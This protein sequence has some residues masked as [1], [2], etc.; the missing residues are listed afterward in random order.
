MCLHQEQKGSVI[1]TITTC[2]YTIT[3]VDTIMLLAQDAIEELMFASFQRLETTHMT[4][5]QN[6][7]DMCARKMDVLQS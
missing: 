4:K 5:I 1:N 3:V 6:L 2:G 7:K